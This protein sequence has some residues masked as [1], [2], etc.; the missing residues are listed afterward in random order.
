MWKSH[1]ECPITQTIQYTIL[2]TNAFPKPKL[3]F[4]TKTPS[5]LI[6][7]FLLVQGCYFDAFVG[8]ENK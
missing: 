8:L 2:R 3:D 7:N 5:T 4:E 1:S 6:M